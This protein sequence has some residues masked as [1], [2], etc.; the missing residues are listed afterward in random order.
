MRL[1]REFGFELGA[2]AAHAGAGRVA[3]LRHESVDHPVKD[4]AVVEAAANESLDV[5]AMPR[6]QIGAHL[7]HYAAGG[8]VEIDCVFEFGCH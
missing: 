2:R 5:G 3:G 1:R 4:D 7:D 8:D 6:R